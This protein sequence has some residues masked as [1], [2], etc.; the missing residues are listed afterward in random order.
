MWLILVTAGKGGWSW[1]EW[2][3]LGAL[4]NLLDYNDVSEGKKKMSAG[5]AGVITEDPV[6]DGIPGESVDSFQII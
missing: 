6:K 5:R 1:D 2:Q 4:K 3:S